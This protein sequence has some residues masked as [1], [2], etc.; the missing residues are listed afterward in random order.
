M[1]VLTTITVALSQRVLDLRLGDLL[2]AI[3]P[4]LAAALVMAAGVALALAMLPPILPIAALA[5]MVML[6]VALYGGALQLIAPERIAEAL[7]FARTRGG[8]EDSEG[9]GDSDAAPAPAE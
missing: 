4:P 5:L 2:V 6:G 7:R 1:A 8:S 3:A 9:E